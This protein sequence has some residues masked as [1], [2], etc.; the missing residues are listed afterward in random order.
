M[1]MNRML[2]TA[3]QQWPEILFLVREGITYSEFMEQ[4]KARATT[5]MEHGVVAGDNVGV[6]AHNIPQ[7]PLT[8]FA[9]WY[10]GARAL[11]LDT[12]LTPFE[13]DNMVE[14]ANCKFVCAEP[15]FFYKT[16]RF[17]FIDITA[18][19]TKTNSE[20]RP[21]KLKDDDI[22]TLSFTSGSTGK[23]KVVPLTHANLVACASSLEDMSEYFS[24]GD[25]MYGFL[26]LY[27]IFGFAIGILATVHFGGGLV[28]QPTV[29]PKYILDDFKKF[30]PHVIPAVPRLWEMFRNKITD[31]LKRQKRWG[32]VDFILRNRE[33][34]T[35]MG[36][37]F[38]VR[39]VQEPILD[40]F[41]GR[42]RLLIAGGAAT[43]PEIETFYENLGLAFIQ[44]YGLTETVGPICISK[45]NKKRI[46]F[47]VGGP[48]T[49]NECEIR[50]KD[51]NGIGVL[52][53]RG[54]QVFGGYMNNDAANKEAFDDKGFFNTG[55]M[56]YMDKNG[57]LHFA[58][59]KKQVIVLDSGKNVYPD[60]LEAMFMDIP[61]VNNVAVFEH[62]VKDKTVA[63]GVFSVDKDMTMEKLAACV[64]D[65]NKKVASYKWVTHFA[66]T[67]DDLPMTSTQK[68]KHHLVRQNLIDGKYPDKH[69]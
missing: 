28:L 16:E 20:L 24:S 45:P 67:T 44:G 5:L 2:E 37:G 11:L 29:N 62:K 10:L 50:D 53:L 51:E 7:F 32:V 57:E 14:I 68:I 43:K 64:A 40:I 21:Y 65:A 26:P 9:I 13:Y 27:H 4:V 17:K 58:G 35:D 15:G 60:E 12:N 47:S 23:P 3:V 59:R 39:K 69:E 22:A 52:W 56:V 54:H 34:I 55:D 42:V 31:T 8:L 33:R 63:Y 49:N 61:G 1:N 25:I 6:L 30:R 46:A 18:K 36:L 19:D 48:T 38:F 41:G 66:M